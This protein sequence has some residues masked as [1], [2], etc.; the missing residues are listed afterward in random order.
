MHAKVPLLAAQIAAWAAVV[1]AER[2]RKRRARRQ[3]GAN[4]TCNPRLDAQTSVHRPAVAAPAAPSRA[5]GQ[6]RS[7]ATLQ[8]R[9]AEGVSNP[10]H[11]G[12][13]RHRDGR[14]AG[15]MG[16]IEGGGGPRMFGA[17]SGGGC[18]LCPTSAAKL[19]GPRG[20]I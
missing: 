18:H 4:A 12:I 10:P 7:A 9:A 13:Q 16:G 11:G 15:V 5:H 3:L 1:S 2:G 17:T 19:G 20:G 14:A 8:R 6:S